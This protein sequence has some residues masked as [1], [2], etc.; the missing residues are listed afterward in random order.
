[1]GSLDE[2][3]ETAGLLP[4]VVQ[5]ELTGEVR[6]VA[7]ASREALAK[8]KQ[9]GRATFFS[10]S[11]SEIWEKG[12]TSGNAIAVS[13]V[14]VDCD[15]DCLLY[16]G[17]PAG[18]SCHTGQE[19]CFF[20]AVRDERGT[21]VLADAGPPT[22]LG[23]LE[24]VLEERRE[25]TAE[26]SYVRSLYDGGPARIGAKITE[27]AGELAAAIASESDERVVSEAADLLFHAMVGLRSRQVPLRRVLAE[28]ARRMGTSG[29]D[30][31]RARGG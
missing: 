11:R 9:T 19:T 6:M 3:F 14:R 27:E 16:A 18:P 10:R 31:K 5:D 24:A 12:A 17:T 30:E 22:A 26:K 29:H 25:S 13:E 2:R 20:R 1:M 15:E 7:W 23:R 4:V 28:I 8:T 21:L